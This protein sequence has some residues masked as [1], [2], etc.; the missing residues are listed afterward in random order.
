MTR[1]RSLGDEGKVLATALFALAVAGCSGS[2]APAET[3]PIFLHQAEYKVSCSVSDECRVQYIDQAGVLRARDIVGEWSLPLGIDPG[4]RMWVRAS[5]GGCPPRP[6]RV[7]IW[8]D[9][10]TVAEN[11]ERAKHRSRCDWLLSE[12]EFVV[13]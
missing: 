12:A 11:L 6:L 8:L 13:P 4:G 5:G 10:R 7:E 2:R 1:T 9:G 3:K